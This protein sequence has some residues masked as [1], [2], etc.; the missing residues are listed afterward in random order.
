MI[1]N[2]MKRVLLVCTSITLAGCWSGGSIQSIGDPTE[3][4]RVIGGGFK[5]ALEGALPLESIAMVSPLREIRAEDG[6]FVLTQQVTNE[7]PYLSND[8]GPV[9]LRYLR[10][11]GWQQ[12]AVRSVKVRVVLDGEMEPLYGRLAI[13]PAA[14]VEERQRVAE[15]FNS[16][17]TVTPESLD[18]MNKDG[19]GL[20]CPKYTQYFQDWCDWALWISKSPL[21]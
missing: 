3:P 2:W 6:S 20:S 14:N 10:G 19:V 15:R 18:Q 21:P 13:F 16:R 11:D 7:I 9:Q 1:R 5:R 17:I 12:S 8:R 4:F